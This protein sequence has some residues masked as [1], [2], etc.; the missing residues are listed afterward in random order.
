MVPCGKRTTMFH[1]LKQVVRQKDKTFAALLNHVRL[2]QINADDEAILKTTVVTI[3]NPKH[4]TD[5][6][7]DME[8]MTRQNFTTVSC[9][10]NTEA[11]NIKC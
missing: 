8:L 9:F 4:F 3:D 7:H 2:A 10:R 1:E 11:F 6:L 5:V